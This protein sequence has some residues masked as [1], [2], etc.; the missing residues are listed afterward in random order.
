MSLELNEQEKRIILELIA[1]EEVQAIQGVDHS[2]TRDYT[3]ILR[4]RLDL[5]AALK[6]KISNS[7]KQVA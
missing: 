6:V 1:N 7:C 2:D 5:L 3:E 4:N